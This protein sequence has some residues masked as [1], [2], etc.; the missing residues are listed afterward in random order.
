[1]TAPQ[2]S[3]TRMQSGR[4][5]AGKRRKRVT[6]TGVLGE[7][8]LTVGALLL[9]FIG[10]KYFYFDGLAGSAQDEAGANLSQQL[11]EQ[12]QTIDEPELDESGIPI[13]PMPE[14]EGQEF[15]VLYVPSWEGNFS[16]TIATGTSFYGVLDQYVGAYEKS[17][18]VGS[19]GNFVIAGHRWGYGSAFKEVPDLSVGDNVYIETVDGWY[20]YTYRSGEYVMPT[21]VSVLAGVPRFPELQSEDRVMILQTCNPIYTSSLERQVAYTVLVDFV[22][23]SDGPPAEIADIFEERKNNNNGDTGGDL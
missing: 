18:P 15:A 5:A 1:M 3:K 11:E 13:R 8:L 10:W 2:H 14:G 20:V 6:F 9:L 7:L 17:D 12:Y 4:R 19:V 23:R 21:E 16:R 22:P